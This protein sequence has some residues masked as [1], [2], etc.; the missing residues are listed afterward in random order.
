MDPNVDVINLSLSVTQNF[1]CVK[2]KRLF[3]IVSTTIWVHNETDFVS[4]HFLQNITYE[5]EYMQILVS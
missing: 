1:T 3:Q 2:T 4:R 5:E